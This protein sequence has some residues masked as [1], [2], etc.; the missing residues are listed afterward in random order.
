MAHLTVW[1]IFSF[2]IFLQDRHLN[3]AFF[4]HPRFGLPSLSNFLDI[5]FAYFI[6]SKAKKTAFLYC[7]GKKPNNLISLYFHA[8]L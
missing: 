3:Y 2:L 1:A 6:A 5:L 8:N 4:I 7:N